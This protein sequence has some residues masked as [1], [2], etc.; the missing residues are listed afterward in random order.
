MTSALSGIGD[1]LPFLSHLREISRSPWFVV[2]T[3]LRQGAITV[4]LSMPGLRVD[5]DFFQDRVEW[6]SFAGDEWVDEDYPRLFHLIDVLGDRATTW[7]ADRAA[8]ANK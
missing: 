6:R 8:Q 7:L 5:V 3:G 4:E 2:L 1:L